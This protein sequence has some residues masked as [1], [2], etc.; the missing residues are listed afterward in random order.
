MTFYIKQNDSL[1]TLQYRMLEAD[2][3]PVNLGETEVE[4]RMG[5]VPHEPIL[6][7]VAEVID[8]DTGLV[9]YTWEA[10]DTGNAGRFKGE[11]IITYPDGKRVSFPNHGYLDIRIESELQ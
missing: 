5:S 9:E 3:S 11:F 6:V 1:P 10:G 8:E 7:G 4:F 2:G